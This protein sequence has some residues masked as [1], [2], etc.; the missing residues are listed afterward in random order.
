MSLPLVSYSPYI[1]NCRFNYKQDMSS[2]VV[3]LFGYNTLQVLCISILF[4]VC[5]RCLKDF[6]LTF[7]NSRQFLTCERYNILSPTKALPFNLQVDFYRINFIECFYDMGT[8]LDEIYAI[9]TD[10]LILIL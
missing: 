6:L 7:K 1:V 4:D 3:S 9:N 2:I 10:I 5:G 8:S